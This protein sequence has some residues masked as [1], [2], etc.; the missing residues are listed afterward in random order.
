MRQRGEIRMDG[1]ELKGIIAMAGRYNVIP[2]VRKIMADTETPIRLFQHFGKERRS[3]LLESVEGG[4][5]WARYSFI[6]T[7]PF[8]VLKLKKGAVT[9]EQGGRKETFRTDDPLGLLR[10]RLRSYRSPS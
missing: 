8:L 6:G 2:V 4:V 3:F 9:L 1:K 10:E 7:D 5:K